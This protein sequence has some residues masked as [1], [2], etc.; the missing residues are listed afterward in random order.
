[1]CK[2]MGI[3]AREIVERRYNWDIIAKDYYEVYRELSL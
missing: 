3:K 1:L 2:K